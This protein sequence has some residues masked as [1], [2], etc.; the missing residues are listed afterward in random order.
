MSPHRKGSAFEKRQGRVGRDDLSD[1]AIEIRTPPRQCVLPMICRLLRCWKEAGSVLA[2][3]SYYSVALKVASRALSSWLA[4]LLGEKKNDRQQEQLEKE[5]LEKQEQTIR[6][7]E[8]DQRQF[9]V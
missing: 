8:R 7:K 6:R 9:I 3:S 1:R 2:T 5:M 4:L